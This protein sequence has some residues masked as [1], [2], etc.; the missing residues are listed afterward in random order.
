MWCVVAAAAPAFAATTE[1]IVAD[2]H[3]GIAIGGFDPVAYFV[4]AGPLQGRPDHEYALGGVTW[5][6]RNEGNRAAFAANPEIYAPQFGGYDPAGIARGVAVPGHPELFLIKGR[7]LYLFYTEESRAAFAENPETVR[8]A[9][10]EKWPD[11]LKT[12]A[13]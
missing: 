13:P 9:A 11:V 5:R 7:R 10:E 8:L 3:S 2:R 6:F 1:R 12:L 4:D